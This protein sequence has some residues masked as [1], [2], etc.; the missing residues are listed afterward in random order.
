MTLQGQRALVTG[1]SRGIGRAIALG[2]AGAGAD[3]ALNFNSSAEAADE[4]VAA[5]G[6]M[7]RKAFAIQADISDFAEA[8]RLV[9]EATAALG[10]ID[11]IV[12]NA[13]ITRD[14]LL[15]AMRPDDFFDVVNTNLGGCFNVTHAAT[16][17][18]IRNRRG[19]IVNITSV[20]GMVGM[21]GQANYSAS[22]AG[23]IGFT[24]AMAKELASRNVTVNAVAPGFVESDMTAKLG[25]MYLKE[26]LKF[27][28]MGRLGNAEEV[29]EAVVFLCSDAARYITGQTIVLDGGLTM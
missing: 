5:I 3:V 29:A 10:G 21:K 23:I 20:S 4:V 25:D 2:L 8:A 19:T 17:G 14:K 7:D 16:R 6:A 22:K 28:P 18:L 1:G 26:M 11:I 24:K 13:G 15:M 12:N 9:K 27:I